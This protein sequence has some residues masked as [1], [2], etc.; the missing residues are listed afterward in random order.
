MP[1]IRN[2]NSTP[3]KPVEMQGVKG[4]RMAIMA[5]REDGVPNFAMR[6]FQVEPNGHAPHHSHDYEHEVYVV[7]GGGTVLLEGKE[8]PIKAGDVV[9]VP[10]DE[11]H[12]FR[13]GDKGMRF[14]CLVPVSR[15]CGDATPGS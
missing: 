9:Y 1:L 12:Q 13:A 8:H 11:E 7:E 14:L 15:N 4:V 3:T 2:V 10:A 5:G 6:H